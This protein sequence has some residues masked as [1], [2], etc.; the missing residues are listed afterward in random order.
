MG[1]T[2]SKGSQVGKQVSLL[3]CA[4]SVC[5][6]SCAKESDYVRGIWEVRASGPSIADTTKSLRIEFTDSQFLVY[7]MQSTWEP[8]KIVGEKFVLAQTDTLDIIEIQRDRM[9]LEGDS[10]TYT[11][12][13][14]KSKK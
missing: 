4:L 10:F 2:I 8:W 6:F 11:Y 3:I 1:I 13:R 12:L 9:I 7:Q 5:F 14:V